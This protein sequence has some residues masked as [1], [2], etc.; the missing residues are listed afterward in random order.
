MKYLKVFLYG[1]LIWGVGLFGS[2]YLAYIIF[3]IIN[4]FY[5]G[6][7]GISGFSYDFYIL[8]FLDILIVTVIAFFLAKSLNVSTKKEM[9][10]YSIF[11]VVLGLIR[12]PLIIFIGPFWSPNIILLFLVFNPLAYILV[13]FTPLLAI[14]SKIMEKE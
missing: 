10:K 4:K 6:N 13:L 7:F 12:I 11:W 2:Q 5:S 9:L 1:I 3:K 8:A 14:K